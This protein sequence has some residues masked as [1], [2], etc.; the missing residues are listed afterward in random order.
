MIYSYCISLTMSLNYSLTVEIALQRERNPS[1]V[2]E[3]SCLNTDSVSSLPIFSNKL[4]SDE[5]P[6]A[7]K[8]PYV[9]LDNQRKEIVLSMERFSLII[10][11]H[12]KLLSSLFTVFVSGHV[13]IRNQ[14]TNLLQIGHFFCKSYLKIMV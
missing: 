7:I 5:K 4:E 1:M 14:E 11:I 2:L 9:F 13:C 6:W 10:R 3:W 12:F 8:R